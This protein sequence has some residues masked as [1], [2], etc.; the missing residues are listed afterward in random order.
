MSHSDR[1]FEARDDFHD[2]ECSQCA[3]APRLMHKILNPRT[4]GTLV[5]YKCACGEQTWIEKRTTKAAPCG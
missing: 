3:A 1:Q 2:V 4:G 5:M